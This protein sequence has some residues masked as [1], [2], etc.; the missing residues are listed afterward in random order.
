MAGF[1]EERTGIKKIQAEIDDIYMYM[2]VALFFFVGADWKKKQNF[3]YF[4]TSDWVI[5]A[6]HL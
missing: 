6:S 5:S 3:F 4:K 2:Y 1:L